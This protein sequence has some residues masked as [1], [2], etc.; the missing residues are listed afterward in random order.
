[1]SNIINYSNW[2][3]VSNES[4]ENSNYIAVQQSGSNEYYTISIPNYPDEISDSG[5]A[6]Y[7]EENILGR[8]SPLI[9]Y[10]GT[11]FRE[12]QFSFDIH[13]EEFNGIDKLLRIARSSVYPNYGTSYMK[14]TITSVRLGD[15]YA[16]GVTRSYGFTWKKPIVNGKY[17]VCTVSL[18]IAD[19]PNKAYSMNDIINISNPANPF[20]GKGV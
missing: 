14:P 17:Q 6:N 13:R 10:T 4:Y 19:I 1:M 15:F 2:N 9:S 11:G 16:R 18:S 8:S 20:H 12:V 3:R 7:S 5:S